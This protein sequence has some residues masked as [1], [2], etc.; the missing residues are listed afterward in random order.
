MTRIDWVL[1]GEWIKSCSCAFGCPCDFNARPTQG[2]CR[3]LLAMNVTQGRFG[4]VVLDGVKFVVMVDFPGPLHEGHGTIQPIVDEA[5]TPSQRDALF[6]I[7][8]GEHSAEGTLFHITSM[9]TETMLDPIFA[10]IEFRFDREGRR[11]AISIPGVLETETQPIKNPVTGAPHRI[12]VVMP[13]GFEHREAEVASAWISSTGGLR[14]DVPEGHSSLAH[15]RQTP[16]GVA[17]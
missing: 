5:A 17:A 14:F 4:D 3:G 12:R 10:P 6:T 13:E 8:S 1:A 16:E 2:W 15:V 11:A 9:I 7:M